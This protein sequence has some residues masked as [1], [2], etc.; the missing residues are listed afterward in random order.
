MGGL[1]QLNLETSYRK[2][3]DD[4]AGSFY[5]PCMARAQTY[6]RAVGFFNSTIYTIAWGSLLTFVKSGGKMRVVCSPL[7]SDTDLEAL[8]SGYDAKTQRAV[9]ESLRKDLEQMLA[10]ST[11]AKPTKVLATLVAL[12]ILDLQ[13]AFIP[14]SAET[15]RR[16]LFH[17]KVGIFR[18]EDGDQVA[19]KGSMNETWNG[20]ANDGNLESVDVFVSWEGRREEGRVMDEV[21]FFER[22]WKNTYP[23]AKVTPFP[24]V[25]K[26]ELLKASDPQNWQA[27]VEEICQTIAQAA[28]ISA[29][30]RPSGRTAKP[31]QI[32]A[33]KN[34][35][36][37]GRHGIFKHATGS[38]KTFTAL[39]TIRESLELGEVPLVL[40]PSE[41]LL[42]QWEGEI[43]ATLRD[44]EP[45][46]L[47]CGGGNAE[48]RRE[49]LLG[50]YTRSRKTAE[51][52]LVL[53][54]VQTASSEEFLAAV[55][56]GEHL[57]LVADEV[58][59]LGSRQNSQVFALETGPR[60]GLSATPERAGD[61]EGTQAIMDY[62]GGIVPPPFTLADALAQRVLTRYFYYVHQVHLTEEE[63]KEWAKY[64]VKIM[65]AL[66]KEKGKGS[67]ENELA[68]TKLLTQRA[69]I[70][71]K[72]E[73]KVPMAMQVIRES[74]QKGQQ[75]IAYCD[76]QDQL[77]SVVDGLK[78]GG[79]PAMEYHSAMLGD[80]SGT[81][82]YFGAHGGILVAIRCLDEGVDIPSVSH[83]LI[84]AS[85]QNP[86]EFI[87]RRGR[88]LRTSQSMEKHL[89]YLHDI[90]VVPEAVSDRPDAGYPMLEAELARAI[91]FGKTAENPAAITDLERIANRFNL[92][93]KQISQSGYET[94]E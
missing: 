66:S 28:E 67:P 47:V 10:I 39:C 15:A 62:F 8:Q 11:T 37:R 64:T 22:L 23:G 80:R 21:D 33:I 76:D 31:H 87:Q 75:W 58:H 83:A 43:K 77:R 84:L 5:L 54:T 41:L 85:S 79:Y 44:L 20:L 26:D 63:Q 46:L 73:A 42:K 45:N 55:D 32:E 86:R 61:P 70:T 82:N 17:D 35:K 51:K 36:A 27:L 29:D 19:F 50:A 18:D 91:E 92:D 2:G 40:V 48:W 24:Q 34:W 60:L 56:E 9:E 94:D 89:A 3:E 52:R 25:P 65:A 72:A 57:F 71:K 69:R 68:L 7:L 12:G 78:R 90:M 59:R 1:R 93:L 74:Y 13:V 6:D 16:R 4:I 81:I 88:L 53:A 49:R 14:A 30:K 38:G